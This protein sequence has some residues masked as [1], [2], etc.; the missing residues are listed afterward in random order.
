MV[1]RSPSRTRRV[2]LRRVRQERIVFVTPCERPRLICG[3]GVPVGSKHFITEQVFLE[4]IASP[5][6]P[7][8]LIAKPISF[9]AKRGGRQS[10]DWLCKLCLLW[11][12]QQEAGAGPWRAGAA[13]A[14]RPLPSGQ[15]DPRDSGRQG[16]ADP[17]GQVG[18]ARPAAATS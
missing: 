1:P 5:V 6:S 4:L 10:S 17:S 9:L 3:E 18:G 15:E 7:H 11:R 14:G 16:W 12:P 2:Q 13:T 8:F